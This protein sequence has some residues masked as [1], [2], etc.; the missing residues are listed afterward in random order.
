M[1]SE[2]KKK[3]IKIAEARGWHD[4]KQNPL[5]LSDHRQLVGF[6]A[7]NLIELWGIPNYFSDLNACHEMEEDLTLEQRV[8]YS[9]NLARICGTEKEKIYATASQRAEAFGLTL[10]LWKP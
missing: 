9:N 8:E 3:Q 10:K 7:S 4:I 6:N 5:C 2:K 1:T